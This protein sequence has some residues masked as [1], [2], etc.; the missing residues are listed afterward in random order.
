MLSLAKLAMDIIYQYYN[1]IVLTFRDYETDFREGLII[2]Y[3]PDDSK[4]F[5]TVCQ[6]IEKQ[7]ERIAETLDPR[8]KDVVVEVRRSKE[9]RELRF[10]KTD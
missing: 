3:V 4:P 2:I 1:E 7:I 5:D 9:H 10:L 8:D 6:K